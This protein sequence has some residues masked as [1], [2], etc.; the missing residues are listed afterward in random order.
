M[1]SKISKIT[2]ISIVALLL[3]SAGSYFLISS[4]YRDSFMINT[5]ING[6]YCTGKEC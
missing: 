1:K 2:L 4:Y 6:V 3:I 5:W